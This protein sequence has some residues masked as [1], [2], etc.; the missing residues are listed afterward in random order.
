VLSAPVRLPASVAPEGLPASVERLV[1]GVDAQ[2]VVDL[3][4]GV[5]LDIHLLAHA[6]YL[7]GSCLSQVSRLAAE[8]QLAAGRA[9]A[10][11]VA[12][13]T[14]HCRMHPLHASAVRLDWRDSFDVWAGKP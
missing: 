8:L 11:P 4:A 14:L 6:S 13:D 2:A 5:I 3:T 12:L 1:A 10:P 7:V 9:L